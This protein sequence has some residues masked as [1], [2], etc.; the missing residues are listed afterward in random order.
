MNMF[1]LVLDFTV[2]MKQSRGFFPNLCAFF[3]VEGAFF[4]F[5]VRN[6]QICAR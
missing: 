5:R 4:D 6:E 1:F 2:F 3:G